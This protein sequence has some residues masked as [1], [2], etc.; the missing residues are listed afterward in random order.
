MSTI[1]V[2]KFNLA[3]RLK[4]KVFRRKFFR[5]AA[6][7]EVAQ[8]IRELRA[9]L[10]MR[11]VDLAKAARMK[12]SAVSRLEQ[13]DYSRWNFKTL[14][15]IADSLDARVRVVF[16]DADNVIKE[17]ERQEQ[18]RGKLAD[19]FEQQ[20]HEQ[21]IMAS[22]AGQLPSAQL[23]GTPPVPRQALRQLLAEERGQ[24]IPE[25]R[26]NDAQQER[27]EII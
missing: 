24:Q 8:Q 16:Q 3:Q 14:L 9:R 11:Q 18:L 23:A 5:T 19:A 22:L 21:A 1:S 10:G 12:Q 25:A 17:Y 15:R 2:T 13:A 4:N 6:Q 26:A 27:I 20:S 7:D